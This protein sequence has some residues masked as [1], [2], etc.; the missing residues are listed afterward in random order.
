MKNKKKQGGQEKPPEIRRVDVPLRLPAWIK[1]EL[2]KRQGTTT[3]NI[4]KAVVEFYK[5]ER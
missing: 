2:Q 5:L 3:E 4:E 1:A